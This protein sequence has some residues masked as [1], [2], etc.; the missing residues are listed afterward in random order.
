MPKMS[1][2]HLAARREQIMLAA[3]ERFA[4]GGF[5]ST[6]MAEVIAASGLSAGAVYRY[7]ASKEEL[8]RAIIHE[9]VLR[10]AAAAFAH[11]V[12]SGLDDPA[13]A[14]AA[15]VGIVEQ[16]GARDG[17]DVTRLALHAW[18]ESLR[19]PQIR[20]L[21]QEAYRTMRGYLSAVAV[22]AQATGKAGPDA[23]PDDIAK[24][25]LSLVIGYLMQ[26]LV[27]RDVAAAGYVSAVGALLRAP[28]AAPAH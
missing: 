15:A 13:E 26:R 7:F 24:A 16:A 2:A 20:E 6:G 19:D 18:S 14:I 21:A 17:V 8:I 5:H 28:V 11:A 25:M 9:R 4:D 23:T 22:R 27:T 12:D 1:D 10:P 3:M